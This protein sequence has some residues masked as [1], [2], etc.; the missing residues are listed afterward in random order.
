MEQ[1]TYQLV[2]DFFHPQESWIPGLV[3]SVVEPLASLF[4]LG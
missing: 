2:Q 3:S 1:S 4:P